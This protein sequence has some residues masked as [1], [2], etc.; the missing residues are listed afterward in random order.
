MQHCLLTVLFFRRSANIQLV[1]SSLSL[2]Y[3]SILSGPSSQLKIHSVPLFH[4]KHADFIRLNIVVSCQSEAETIAPK[5][6]S[7]SL[8]ELSDDEIVQLLKFGY[9]II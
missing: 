7:E 3:P 8:N 5:I 9:H 1:Y 2:T 4:K 6:A